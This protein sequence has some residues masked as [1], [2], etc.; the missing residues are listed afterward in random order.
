MPIH[1]PVSNRKHRVGQFPSLKLGRMVAFGSTLGHDLLYLLDFEQGIE[2]FEEQPLAIPYSANGKARTYTPD[3]HILRLGRNWLVECRPSRYVDSDDNRLK[4]Q[5]AHRWC[6]ERD[7]VFGVVLD[8]ALHS[9][10]YLLNIKHITRYSRYSVEAALRGMVFERLAHGATTV[11]DLAQAIAPKRSSVA[12]AQ[13][14]CMVFR[15]E[16]VVPTIH[17]APLSIHS[18]VCLSPQGAPYVNAPDNCWNTFS[19]VGRETGD[20]LPSHPTL[21]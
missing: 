1:Q 15:H 8:T 9:T 11:T 6:A 16:I 19:L 4:F 20:G 5:A 17:T 13:I 3:F 14:W 7:W 2:T 10:P 12:I 21:A 18:A